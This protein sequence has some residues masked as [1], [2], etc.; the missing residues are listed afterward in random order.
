MAFEVLGMEVQ[1]LGIAL[2]RTDVH[3]AQFQVPRRILLGSGI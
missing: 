1:T 3:T 2:A